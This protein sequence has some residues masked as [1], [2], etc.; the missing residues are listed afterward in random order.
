V[1][2]VDSGQFGAA[3]SEAQAFGAP[4]FGVN[5]WFSNNRTFIMDA[6]PPYV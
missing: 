3:Q 2:K 6:G 5:G 1:E 4:S